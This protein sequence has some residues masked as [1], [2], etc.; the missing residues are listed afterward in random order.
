MLFNFQNQNGNLERMLSISL[1]KHYLTVNP[2]IGRCGYS[3]KLLTKKQK[4]SLFLTS[5]TF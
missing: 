1:H 3:C 2:L 4:H 5:S